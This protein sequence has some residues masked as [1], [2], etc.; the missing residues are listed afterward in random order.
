MF[1]VR[2]LIMSVSVEVR[3]LYGRSMENEKTS[4]AIVLV[5][6]QSKNLRFLSLKVDLSIPLQ[7]F[8]T[9]WR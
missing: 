4:Q 2:I 7:S 6:M 5:K 9:A 8:V 3:T 1:G